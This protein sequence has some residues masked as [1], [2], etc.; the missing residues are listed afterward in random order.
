MTTLQEKAAEQKAKMEKSNP[1]AAPGKPVEDRKRIPISLPQQ[2]LE[3]PEIPGFHLHWFRGT[4]QRLAQAEQAGYVFVE[5]DEV[6]LTNLSLGGDAAKDG[7]TDLGGRVSIYEGGDSVDAGGQAVRLYLMKQ[8]MEYFLEDRKILDSR[9]DSVAHALTTAYR[10]EG[11][12]AGQAPGETG[13]DRAQR[14][15]DPKRTRVPELFKKK[16]AK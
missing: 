12:G 15:V 5:R 10:T 9:N 14:Y 16:V 8:P 1:S 4:P 13:A 7:N 11:I 2:K 3:V 6:D